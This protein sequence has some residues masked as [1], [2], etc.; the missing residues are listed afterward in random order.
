MGKCIICNNRKAKR[1]CPALNGNICS[2]CWGTKR[3]KEVTCPSSREYL[4]TGEEYQVARQI[5]KEMSPTFQTEDDE[6]LGNEEVIG[7][8]MPLEK[9]F[10]EKFY[11]DKNADDN[12]IYDALVKIYFY[13]T[14]AVDSLKPD[15]RCEELIF[16]AVYAIDKSLVNMPKDLKAKSILRLLKS[17]KSSSG[18]VLGARNYSEMVYSQFREDGRW[19]NLFE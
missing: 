5:S 19:N 17:I 13:L 2:L 8:V 16:E 15:N 3:K 12:N 9:F 11:Y 1:F 6:I 4:K 7:F 18:G 14:K 10:L